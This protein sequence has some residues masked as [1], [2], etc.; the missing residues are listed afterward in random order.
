MNMTNE[1]M[2]TDEHDTKTVVG[3]ELDDAGKAALRAGDSI[4]IVTPGGAVYQGVIEKA[5]GLRVIK[6]ERIV[7]LGKIFDVRKHTISSVAAG[8]DVIDTAKRTTT[9]EE[10]RD[11][12][13]DQRGRQGNRVR[14][15]GI[16]ALAEAL[17]GFR[18]SSAGNMNGIP[19]RSEEAL[20]GQFVSIASIK[21]ALRE[22]VEAGAVV[23]V[24][25]AAR[26]ALA[27]DEH[28]I[29]F[30]D[31]TTGWVL[32]EEYD[33]ARAAYERKVAEAKT[34]RFRAEARRIVAERYAA[35]VE[36]LTAELEASADAEVGR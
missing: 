11:I 28:F 15:T 27:F 2:W 1:P 9:A 30:N 14:A 13:A 12:I 29:F 33:D 20:A 8:A 5:S 22:L 32:R 25:A 10:I 24:K 17:N 26:G 4:R 16:V 34:E 3:P 19:V 18:A 6:T 31:F 36:T 23:E 21:N 35:E 7:L